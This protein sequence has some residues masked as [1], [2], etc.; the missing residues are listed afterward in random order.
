VTQLTEH[1]PSKYEAL[2]LNPPVP[3]KKKKL[4]HSRS[5]SRDDLLQTNESIPF[6]INFT[7]FSF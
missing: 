1:L 4:D 7:A 6:L 5:L 3:P 2:S